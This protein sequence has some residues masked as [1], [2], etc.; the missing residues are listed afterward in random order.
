MDRETPHRVLNI[1]DR[2]AGRRAD[3]FLSMRFPT[4]SRSTFAKWI[5][6]G[7]V[8]SDDRPL[9]P[10]TVLRLGETLRIWAPGIAPTEGPPPMPP[11]VY[12]DEWLLA[13]DKPP[14]LLVHPVGQKFA[15]ALI[16]LVREVRPGVRIDLSHRLDRETS[17][18]VLLTKHED[19]NRAMKDAFMGRRVKKTYQALV[20]GVVPWESKTVD[21][22]LGHA[23]GSEVQLRRG[24]D[25]QGE[26]ALTEVRVLARTATHTL[27]EC[28]PHTGRTHQIRAHLEIAGFPIL[29]DKLYGQPDDVFLEMLDHGAT[30]RVRAT[31]GFPRHALHAQALAFPHPHSGQMLKIRAPLPADMQAVVD[32]AAPVWAGAEGEAEVEEAGDE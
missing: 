9:K 20:R 24:H 18:I 3:T 30:D 14:G 1:L 26:S 19:A 21:A 16:G 11:I 25:P 5:K 8:Q 29:G 4:W 28:Q 17:G 13:V 27:V 7:L 10:S 32:G 12:E 6:T 23:A 15:W 2:A 31:I 22:S